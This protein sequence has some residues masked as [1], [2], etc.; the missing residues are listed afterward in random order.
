MADLEPSFEDFVAADS[1][2][3]LVLAF[4]LTGN[5]HDPWDLTDVRAVRV[6]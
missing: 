4:A 5:T 2:R 6:T 1:R 3:L